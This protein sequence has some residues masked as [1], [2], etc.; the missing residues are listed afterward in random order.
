MVQKA[1]L[2]AL[3]VTLTGCALTPGRSDISNMPIDCKNAV[4]QIHLLEYRVDRTLFDADY[5]SQAEE[6]IWAIRST[7]KKELRYGSAY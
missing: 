5:A 7:C 4:M 6:K 2:I 3:L 1:T